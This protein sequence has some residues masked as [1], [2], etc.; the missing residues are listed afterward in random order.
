MKLPP[1][2]LVYQ[3]SAGAKLQKAREA[4]QL[5]ELGEHVKGLSGSLLSLKP[6]LRSS[7]LRTVASSSDLDLS[8]Q[9]VSRAAAEV[10]R[11]AK[12]DTVGLWD[13]SAQVGELPRVVETLNEAQPVITFFEVQ[14]AIQSGLI[15]RPERMR[16]WAKERLGRPLTRKEAASFASGVIFEEFE[17]KADKVRRGLGIDH[18]IGIV[19]ALVASG[20]GPEVM[21][22]LYSAG[23]SGNVLV[24]TVDVYAY[25]VEAGRPFEV[26]V[27]TIALSTRLST[28]NPR[29]EFHQETRGCLFDFDDNRA[30]LVQGLRRLEIEPECLAKIRPRYREAALAMMTALQGLS[31]G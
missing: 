13:L 20:D 1:F 5:E 28:L 4:R 27:A 14:A 30:D 31:K 24:S 18:L 17:E 25:A 7:L 21:W 26:A 3:P 29:A 10:T 9:T 23:R 6:A 12:V 19:P 11:Q 8:A 2:T 16:A 22:D 15:S